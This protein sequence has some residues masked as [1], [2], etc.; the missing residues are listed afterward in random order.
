MTAYGMSY[1]RILRD[2]WKIT[3]AGIV[4]DEEKDPEKEL[5]RF[6]KSTSYFMCYA[7]GC[8]T[9]CL[10]RVY[11]QKMIDAVG[12]AFI[13]C[14]TDSVFASDPEKSRAAIRKLEKSL[15]A[16]QR[17]CGMQLTYK[18]IKGRD[19]ELGG[20]DE[21]PECSIKTLGAKKYITIIDGKIQCT[22]AGVPKKAGSALIKSADD[23]KLGMVFRGS[24]TN[25]MC[26]WYN[27]DEDIMLWD[28]GRPIPVYSNVAMLPVDYLLG[29][30]SDYRLCL[31]VEGINGLFDFK[32]ANVNQ[33]E[34]YI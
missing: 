23:F 32:E 15:K 34:D 26:L 11:L 27:D 13:Y 9:A 30:S 28:A 2:L 25:K 24:D 20:I 33:N 6:Q 29:I 14:D 18:D 17:K 21:E 22:I 5:E 7:W 12:D 4:L 16:Y 1:T 10:G 19:H 31:Q 3:D 8:M